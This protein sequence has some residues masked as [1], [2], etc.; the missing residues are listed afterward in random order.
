MGFG[1]HRYST[2]AKWLVPHFEKMLYDQAMLAMAYTEA[3]EATRDEKL[4]QIAREIITYVLRDM[5]D[6]GGGFY[7]AE[8]A[9]TEGEEGKFYTWTEEEIRLQIPADEARFGY[10]D[11]WR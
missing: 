11:F 10:G 4:K 1:F 7:L 5:T 2:D 8:D 3:Y 9:D 6:S